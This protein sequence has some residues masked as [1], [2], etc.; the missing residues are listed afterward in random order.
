VANRSAT[1]AADLAAR[2]H[3]RVAEWERLADAV[4]EADVIVAATAAPRAVVSAALLAG[5]EERDRTFVDLGVPRN[6]HEDVRQVPG[7]RV[8][9]VDA[10]R[11]WSGAGVGVDARAAATG[12]SEAEE[13]VERWVARFASW[14]R[15]RAH[16]RVIRRLRDEA[17]ELRDA[18][19]ARALARL[20]ALSPREREVVRTLASRLVNKMLHHPLV[21]LAAAPDN[22]ALADPARRRFGQDEAPAPCVAAAQAAVLPP[23]GSGICPVTGAVLPAAALAP[24][25]AHLPGTPHLAATS[26]LA[27]TPHLPVAS[28][29][30]P[31]PRPA[32]AVSAA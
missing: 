11:F 23:A 28:L 2:H 27:A 25:S 16:I 10:L 21:A 5:A 9:D 24:T 1:R 32:A 8:L 26:H 19:V 13:E 17:D 6:V 7:A 4:A 18:E 12:R 30:A 3:A 14:Q 22:A 29:P 31:D 20:G 15:S